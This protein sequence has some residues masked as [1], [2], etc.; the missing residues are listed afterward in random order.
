MLSKFISL[1]DDRNWI[2]HLPDN[3]LQNHCF[4][5]LSTQLTTQRTPRRSPKRP[6]RVSPTSYKDK[7]N[8]RPS[9][10]RARM[11]EGMLLKDKLITRDIL[12]EMTN[13]A[14]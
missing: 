6:T 13:G 11:G 10:R 3:A 4:E 5:D 1:M 2:Y 14:Y 12:N 8:K 9:P 7:E